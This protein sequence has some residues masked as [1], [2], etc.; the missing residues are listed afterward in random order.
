M[1]T[2]DAIELEAIKRFCLEES[3]RKQESSERESSV[4]ELRHVQKQLKAELTA[5]LQKT[6]KKVVALT[7]A[8]CKSYGDMCLKNNHLSLPPILRIVRTNKDLTITPEVIQEAIECITEEDLKDAAASAS[9]TENRKKEIMK[10]AILTNLRRIIR[11]YNESLKLLSS[12]PRTE[13]LY[14]VDEADT[15]TSEKMFKMWST[16]QT[17]KDLLK[18]NKVVSNNSEIKAKVE[19]YFI[20]TGL[21]A[22][23]II[24]E[25]KPFRLVR[26]VSIQKP[27]IGI[28][29]FEA[30]LNETLETSKD[31]NLNTLIKNLQIQ[32]TS[33]PPETKS[34]VSL[35]SIKSE[36]KDD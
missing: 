33:Q 26:R 28:G 22:Q 17:I 21:T 13:S 2:P 32:L 27:K 36:T 4:K 14:D 9:S 1:E 8:A 31:L 35:C 10:S 29:K 16:E 25:G 18:E 20:R 23:R 24:V 12:L 6:E 30:I 34:V 19:S 15:E 11:S 5:I 7:K 3:K